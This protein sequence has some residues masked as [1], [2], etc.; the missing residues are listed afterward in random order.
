MINKKISIAL[1]LSICL[2]FCS[3]NV[4]E[5]DVSTNNTSVANR[6][7]NKKQIDPIDDAAS[8]LYT[9]IY[10]VII[11]FNYE[12]NLF[13][14]KDVKLN[15]YIDGSKLCTFKQGDSA[16]FGLILSKGNHDISVSSSIFNSSTK[17][18]YVGKN[19]L[20]EEN[21]PDVFACTLKF[22]KNKAI[23]EDIIDSDNAFNDNDTELISTGIMSAVCDT[24]QPIG[25]FNAIIKKYEK[26]H[27]KEKTLEE[28]RDE[29]F[30]D[31]EVEN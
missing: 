2:F 6:K 13:F 25:N 8:K 7:D 14:K 20:F 4:Q 17:T 31:S 3:C 1:L 9:T 24:Y 10:P 22:K 5:T 26:K 23:L 16:I 12:E 15:L 29:I 21:F 30:G 11:S 19:D 27:P 18:F 28:I